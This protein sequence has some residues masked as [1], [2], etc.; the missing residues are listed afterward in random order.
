MASVLQGSEGP[1]QDREASKA[2]EIIGN[3]NLE[4]D[5][6]RDRLEPILINQATEANKTA[7]EVERVAESNLI[8]L[9]NG[10]LWKVERIKGSIDL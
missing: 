2:E 4:I 8:R 3:I 5:Q 10:I 7:A 1:S 9:L 6:I